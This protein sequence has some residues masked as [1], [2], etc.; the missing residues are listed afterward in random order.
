MTIQAIP[1]RYKGY[2][3]RSRLEARWAVFMDALRVPWRY[4]YEGYIL[5]D[6]SS[7]LPDFEVHY[8][9]PNLRFFLEIKAKH[10][11]EQELAK[12]KL[13]ANDS[14]IQIFLYFGEVTQPGPDLSKYI[15]EDQLPPDM[16]TTQWFWDDKIGWWPDTSWDCGTPPIWAIGRKPTGYS[17]HPG[18]SGIKSDFLWWTEC[19]YCQTFVI[20]HHGCVAGCPA[21]NETGNWPDSQ[22]F[23]KALDAAGGWMRAFAYRHYTPAL[24]KAY[25]AA[26]SAR[27]EHGESGAT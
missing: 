19:P 9:Q 6:G 24:N 7:Y 4:E 3:F 23:G 1:T 16:T 26:R 20:T 17:F 25:D 8:D 11:A 14:G 27:F 15:T 21:L 5:S 22:N 10:P 13:L 12:A 18:A 2:H